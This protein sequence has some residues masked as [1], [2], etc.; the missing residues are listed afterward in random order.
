M[1]PRDPAHQRKGYGRL[2]MER[3]EELLRAEGCPKFNLQVR[4][5]NEA[6]LAFYRRLGFAP[7]EVVSL[8]KRLEHDGPPAG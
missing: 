7:D 2:M 1:K 4:T 3:A 5:S 6:V 8:S